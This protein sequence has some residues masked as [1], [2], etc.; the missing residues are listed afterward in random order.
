[1]KDSEVEADKTGG[2]VRMVVTMNGAEVMMMATRNDAGVRMVTATNCDGEKTS[3][4]RHD[5]KEAKAVVGSLFALHR[6]RFLMMHQ[7][8]NWLLV[9][10]DE[11]G[12]MIWKRRHRPFSALRRYPTCSVC[13]LQ[14]YFW[15]WIVTKR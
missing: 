10:L 14:D 12:E 6:L 11:N 5:V 7:G 9:V 13:N 3:L 1:M 4:V 8:L 2:G 15:E